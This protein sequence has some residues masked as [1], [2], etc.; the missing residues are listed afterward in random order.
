MKEHDT[1]RLVS[2]VHAEGE[3]F[4]AGTVGAI[5]AVYANGELFAVE[6]QNMRR[7]PVILTVPSDFLE[8]VTIRGRASHLVRVERIVKQT[9]YFW[10]EADTPADAV[11]I[12][13][14]RHAW[15]HAEV[16]ETCA[17]S[18]SVRDMNEE[19]RK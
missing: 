14:A 19:L 7:E 8:V 9:A 15:T 4:A 11:E 6:T 12:A 3:V 5:V 16:L 1:V 13:K 2:S 18:A 17:R 10:Q